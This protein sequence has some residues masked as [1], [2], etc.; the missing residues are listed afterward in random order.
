MTRFILAMGKP[1]AMGLPLML[2]LGLLM[3]A[4]PR[5]IAADEAQAPVLTA[6][7]AEDEAVT[8][9][10]VVVTVNRV[11]QDVMD[12]PQSVSVITAEDIAKMPAT[13]ITEILTR[14]PG[15]DIALDLADNSPDAGT[16]H[17]SLRGEST[18]R[19]LVLING[20]K[21]VEANYGYSV[22]TI[23]PSQIERIEVVKGPSSV[24][25][26][27]EAIGGVVNIITKK[28][29]GK[30]LGFSA[31]TVFDSSTDGWM[32]NGAVFG[33]LES[34]LSYRVSADAA[35]VGDR[36]FPS[37]AYSST[38]TMLE[39]GIG[40]GYRNRNY[41]AQLGYDWDK[42]SFNIQADRFESDSQTSRDLITA[43]SSGIQHTQSTRDSIMATFTGTN[44]T[45]Y[46]KTLMI[47][48]SFSKFD[49]YRFTEDYFTNAQ[50]GTTDSI[51]NQYT[52]AIQAEWQLG[53][54]NVLTGFEWEHGIVELTQLT[55]PT[56]TTKYYNVDAVIS[57][58]NMAFFAQDQWS[59]TDKFILTVGLRQIWNTKEY[60]D[61][62]AQ[63][64]PTTGGGGG[65]STVPPWNPNMLGVTV[66]YSDL[67]GNV[68]LVYK[69]SDQLAF[70]VLA[71]QGKRYPTLTQIFTSGRG[72]G[73]SS[74]VNVDLVPE[75]S[76]SY[77]LGARYDG[78]SLSLDTSVFYTD[79]KDFI[80]QDL[81][82]GTG[83]FE[84]IGW[85]KTLGFD[86]ST[87]YALHDLGL[88]PYANFTMMRR[89]QTKGRDR[90]APASTK[91]RTPA[92]QGKVGIQYERPLD[93]MHFFSD[94]RLDFAS[95]A[96]DVVTARAAS[97]TYPG[98][99]TLNLNLG[100]SGG[101]ESQYSVSVAFNNILDKL[102]APAR[103]ANGGRRGR[104]LWAPGR[105]VVLG[106]NYTY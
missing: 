57:Q 20:V 63:G 94:L 14:I 101:D 74:A 37:G 36:K 41:A 55:L 12:I 95:G 6:Q 42:Y 3:G 27:P 62:T 68:G 87:S 100:L 8:T 34:G 76:M 104:T 85:A 28:G 86:L 4:A 93:S 89:E 66:S 17:I 49:R 18:G 23:N 53:R 13:T 29:G 65:Y 40:S 47:K 9:K 25:Y 67:I 105:H 106:L 46:L 11:I 78:D 39:K 7:L 96:D 61:W 69:H 80:E 83:S 44:L 56:A 2:L 38:G 84:N 64:A 30:P 102:Y 45:D 32:G 51:N 82:G 58:D 72:S 73:G 70:R 5:E 98:W 99:A 48:S 33:R 26:G 54:H 21:T 71:S 19:T 60:K 50:T 59:F 52:N 10:S 88:T 35:N 75:S 81:N 15:L 97:A 1:A 79:A 31:G 90:R 43:K 92:I 103:S 22:V 77:E 24:L 91:S 16:G